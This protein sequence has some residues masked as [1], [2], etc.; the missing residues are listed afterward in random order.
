[1]QNIRLSTQSS[2]LLIFDEDPFLLPRP[3]RLAQAIYSVN[4]R[5]LKLCFARFKP[6]FSLM[7]P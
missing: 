6:G 5:S 1:M 2:F 4:S 3:T 7:R